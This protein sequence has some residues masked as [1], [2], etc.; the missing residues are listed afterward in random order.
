M[1]SSN[2]LRAHIAQFAVCLLVMLGS[3]SVRD[4]ETGITGQSLIEN[5]SIDMVFLCF[6]YALAIT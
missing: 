4:R 6:G 2:L 3:P 5:N 1:Y